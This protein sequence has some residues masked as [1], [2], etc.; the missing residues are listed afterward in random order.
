MLRIRIQLEMWPVNT[1]KKPDLK[2]G[3]AG[4]GTRIPEE[5]GA[6]TDQFHEGLYKNNR[7]LTI[8]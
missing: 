7:F 4:R 6:T 3:P 2:G 5:P 1:Y 8:S